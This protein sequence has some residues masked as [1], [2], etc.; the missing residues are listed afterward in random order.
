LKGCRRELHQPMAIP[1][2]PVPHM[3]HC[4]R[5]DV[6]KAVSHDAAVCRCY[7][8][9]LSGFW[10]FSRGLL[11]N[12]YLYVW[13]IATLQLFCGYILQFSWSLTLC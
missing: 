5:C 8:V 11:T 13:W 2:V 1:T 4:L 6:L 9:K 3:I 7:S 12:K 10:N